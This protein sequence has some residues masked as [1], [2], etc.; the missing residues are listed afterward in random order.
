MQE[1]ELA[2]LRARYDL[3]L[4]VERVRTQ[5]GVAELRDACDEA[6]RSQQD[7]AVRQVE[8]LRRSYEEASRMQR[9]AHDAV[10]SAARAEARAGSERATR[11]LQEEV[12]ALQATT[13]ELASSLAKARCTTAAEE[14]AVVRLRAE[15]VAEA[16][17]SRQAQER[18]ATQLRERCAQETAEMRSAFEEQRHEMAA[19]LVSRFER[20]HFDLSARVAAEVRARRAAEHE[21]N[22]LV[23]LFESL[24]QS[25]RQCLEEPS[26][27]LS[28]PPQLPP[29]VLPSFEE[30]GVQTEDVP[31][32]PLSPRHEALAMCLADLEGQ[33]LSAEEAE[34]MRLQLV[35]QRMRCTVALKNDMIDELKTE[36]WRKESEILEARGILAG[37]N[38]PSSPEK[39]RASRTSSA[40]VVFRG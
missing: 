17:S 33:L 13:S 10:L 27:L 2:L 12:L 28:S 15:S 8:E 36:L 40:T 30:R 9:A 37:L 31:L 5:T 16:R 32:P 11:G 24:R 18:E 23:E 4:D 34:A 38:M 26:S 6:T 19:E 20:E 25:T 39:V 21:K 7:A 35:E 14:V 3:R 1:A 22:Q 29:T